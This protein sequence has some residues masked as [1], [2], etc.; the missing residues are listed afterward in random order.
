[1]GITKH[2]RKFKTQNNAVQ[3]LS[4]NIF[5]TQHNYYIQQ[6]QNA[7]YRKIIIYLITFKKYKYL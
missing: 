4:V 2:T 5:T 6:E 7:I 1:M 3:G